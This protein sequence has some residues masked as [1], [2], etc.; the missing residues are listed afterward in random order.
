[1]AMENTLKGRLNLNH[2]AYKSARGHILSI[3]NQANITHVY[4]CA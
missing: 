4:K 2:K 3:R 1:M